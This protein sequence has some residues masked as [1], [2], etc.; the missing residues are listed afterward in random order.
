M[1]NISLKT[2]HERRVI[3]KVGFIEISVFNYPWWI[4][5]I[6]AVLMA[7][8]YFAYYSLVINI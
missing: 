1:K 6:S 5:I 8:I 2:E 3:I 4:M 7:V